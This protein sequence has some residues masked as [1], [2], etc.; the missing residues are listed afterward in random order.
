MSILPKKKWHTLN[1]DNRE[2]VRKDELEQAI[3]NE[4]E[5]KTKIEQARLSK[6]DLLRSKKR[7]TSNVSEKVTNYQNIRMNST[8]QNSLTKS[9]KE[10][11]EL[12]KFEKSFD[13]SFPQ[14]SLRSIPWYIQPVQSKS[15]SLSNLED[16]LCLFKSSPLP[17]KQL[18]DSHIKNSL[19]KSMEQL[20]K[21]RLE[22]E[23]QEKRKRFR[24][25]L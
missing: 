11:L 13:V 7:K 21:E 14:K 9:Q 2:R 22:R 18:S 23:M 10:K 6:L 19:C 5:T 24:Y 20:R 12:E 4:V 15:A 25:E 16:P 1:V 3:Y 8:K 17:T